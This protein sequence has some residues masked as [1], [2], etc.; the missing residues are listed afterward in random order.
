MA[1][2]LVWITYAL[3]RSIGIPSSGQNPPNPAR[4]LQNASNCCIA[5][6]RSTPDP[7]DTP[8]VAPHRHT[9]PPTGEAARRSLTNS[10]P[11]PGLTATRRGPRR[12]Q[13]WRL[14]C[15]PHGRPQPTGALPHHNA[16]NADTATRRPRTPAC[17]PLCS[18]WT[19]AKRG[20]WVRLV[21]TAAWNAYTPHNLHAVVFKDAAE[22]PG[23]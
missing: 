5:A 16:D 7:G 10:R 12:G 6:R 22:L 2:A 1:L 19:H 9:A 15:Q 3:L 23:E 21:F 18:S 17:G 11:K 13:L 4:A 8:Q 14:G 20:G